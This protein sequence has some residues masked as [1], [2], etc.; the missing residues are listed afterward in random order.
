M[1][2]QQGKI[3][4][5]ILA[6]FLAGNLPSRLRNEIAAYLAQDESA[7]ELLGMAGEALDAAKNEI[8]DGY[9]GVRESERRQRYTSSRQFVRVRRATLY[10]TAAVLTILVG[11]FL[12]TVLNNFVSARHPPVRSIG[13]VWRPVFGADQ[14]GISW[15]AIDGAASYVV[16]VMD[17][18]SEKLVLRVE[19]TSTSISSLFDTSD[20]EVPPSGE[21]REL[22]ISAFGVDGQLLRR[23]ERIPFRV[24]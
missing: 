10:T 19:T 21:V 24:D 20:S 7:L 1:R 3:D 8:G 9:Y 12:F 11:L 5:N 6:G 4:E 13:I 22:W 16:M 2:R 18:S 17:P 15:P 23:S 14:F